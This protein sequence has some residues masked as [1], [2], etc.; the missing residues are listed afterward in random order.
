MGAESREHKEGKL[1]GWSQI[2]KERKD[3]VMS[4]RKPEKEIAENRE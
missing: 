3:K 1:R 4:E 2:K